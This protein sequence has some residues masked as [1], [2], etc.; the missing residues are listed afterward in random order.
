MGSFTDHNDHIQHGLMNKL[1]SNA[2]NA[3]LFRLELSIWVNGYLEGW[4]QI[5]KKLATMEWP[6]PK[7]IGELQG[8]L[9]LIGYYTISSKIMETS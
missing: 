5:L 2:G 3:T 7:S 6:I 9:G 1:Y 4:R 8:F